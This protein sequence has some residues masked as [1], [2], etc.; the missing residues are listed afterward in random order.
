MR[1]AR[2]SR[3]YSVLGWM[4]YEFFKPCHWITAVCSFP[5]GRALA[6]KQKQAG[7][8]RLLQGQRLR[9]WGR[10]GV[11]T[12]RFLVPMLSYLSHQQGQPVS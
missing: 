5:P 10:G 3:S 9:Q 7:T 4:D 6:G 1:F 8:A 11:L 2:V 12:P